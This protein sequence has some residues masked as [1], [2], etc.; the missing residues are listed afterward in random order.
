MLLDWLDARDATRVGAALADDFVT[1]SASASHAA[2]Q[3][4]PR[5]DAQLQRLLQKFMQRVEREA[6]SLQLNLFKRAKLANSFKWRLLEKGVE[7]QVVDELTQALV[8]RLSANGSTMPVNMVLPRA[9]RLDSAKPQTLIAKAHDCMARGAYAEAVNCYQEFLGS[10][11]RHALARNQLGEALSRLGHYREA[12]DQF[13][14]AIRIRT[15]FP[16]ALCNLGTVLRLTGRFVEAE[17]PLRRALKL[18]PAYVEAQVNL[19]LTLV[20]LARLREARLY[21]EKVLRIAPHHVGALAGLGQIAAAEGRLEVAEAI[22]RRVLEIDPKMPAAWM[23]S[24]QLR[25]MT[26][27]DGAWL[28][29]AEEAATSA[30][31]PPEEAD[32]RH[33]IGKYYDDVGDFKRAFRSHQRANELRKKMAEAYDRGAHTQFVDDLIRVYTRAALSRAYDGASDSARP[34]FV[35]GMMRSGTS[36]VE[37]I[38]ASHRAVR[39]AGELQFWRDAVREHESTIRQGLIDEPLRRKLAAAYLRTLDGR[40]REVLRV[41]DK[42]TFNSDFLGIIHTVFPNARMIHLRRDPIDT[43]LSCYFQPFSAGH[44]FTMDLADLA[45]Y[46]REHHRLV[47]HWRRVLP[48]GTLLDVPYEELIADQETWARRILDFLGMEWDERC[49]TFQGADTIVLTASYWQVRQKIYNSSV[50]RWRNY[51]KFIAPLL[52]LRNLEPDSR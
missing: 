52:E 12:E 47:A 50:G 16:E 18:K 38:I 31:S 17:M 4:P 11:P 10:E 14:R 41:V 15:G 22:Y 26:A 48:A 8:M 33:A 27:A 36:L 9:T 29:G 23:V 45:H 20:L 34:V 7:P 42:A 13:R 1:Q 32:I 3:D 43:C 35:V 5:A 19:G 24:A 46:Y 51:E 28:K 6:R 2:P 44:S 21:L 37:Q 25:T 39:G 49:L 40:C 30:R